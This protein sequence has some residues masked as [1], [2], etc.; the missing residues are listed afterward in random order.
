MRVKIKGRKNLKQLRA[1]LNQAVDDME[2]I[3]ITH[4]ARTSIYF[5]PVDEDGDPQTF[6][7][8]RRKFEEWTIK[9]GYESAADEYD[10]Q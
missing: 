6:H 2:R 8:H 9:S 4:A 1:A 5:T 10:P 7:L 3:G